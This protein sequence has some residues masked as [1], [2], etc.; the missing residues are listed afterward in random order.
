MGR[1]DQFFVDWEGYSPEEGCWVPSWH[2]LDPE[3]ISGFRGQGSE[4]TTGVVP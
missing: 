1:G 2:I 3:L 4:R